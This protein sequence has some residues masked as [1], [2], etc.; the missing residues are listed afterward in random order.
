M[1]MGRLQP[2][3]VQVDSEL[4]CWSLQR[5]VIS[6]LF[7]VHWAVV[8]FSE[9]FLTLKWQSESK[10]F[11]SYT[12]FLSKAPTKV[13]PVNS[14][15]AFHGLLSLLDSLNLVVRVIIVNQ[16]SSLVQ[17]KS[18]FIVCCSSKCAPFW[19]FPSLLCNKTQKQF[20]HHVW[21][22][23][24]RHNIHC[25]LLVLDPSLQIH[26]QRLTGAMSNGHSHSILLDKSCIYPFPC[27]SLYAP[28]INV[29]NFSAPHYPIFQIIS[30]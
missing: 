14:L 1:V 16:E 12:R 2:L 11:V 18:E 23:L 30:V 5:W 4:S 25:G 28:S 27:N 10:R 29:P 7:T 13:H 15:L 19:F 20:F 24:M 6:G 3:P 9:Y 21:S 22:T 26:C 17:I 8:F